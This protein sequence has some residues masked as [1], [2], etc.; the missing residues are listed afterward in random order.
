[1]PSHH[2]TTS[3]KTG[4][5][6][7]GQEM[8]ECIEECQNCHTV[9]V[10]TLAYCLEKGGDHANAEHILLLQDCAQICTTSADFMLRGSEL[11]AATCR[12]C[13][14]VCEACATHCEQFPDDEQM[15]KCAQACRD[16]AEG[17]REMAGAA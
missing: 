12:A 3:Q 10:E 4:G 7:H 11:H 17:C 15:K 9:C 13:A 6:Q 8:Q 16:C 1:M 5:Q 14:E 2:T